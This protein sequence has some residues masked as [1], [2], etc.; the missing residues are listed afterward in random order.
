MLYLSRLGAS[1]EGAVVLGE[2]LMVKEAAD[3]TGAG[4]NISTAATASA[5]NA[6]SN[7]TPS[8]MAL[9]KARSSASYVHGCYHSV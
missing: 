6:R 5:A 2:G 1:T 8:S 4:P 9:S 7:A 3:S